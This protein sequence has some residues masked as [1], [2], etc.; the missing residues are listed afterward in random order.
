MSFHSFIDNNHITR[1]KQ[2]KEWPKSRDNPSYQKLCDNFRFSI[3]LHSCNMWRQ[4]R[5]QKL[6]SF[7]RQSS[8]TLFIPFPIDY[9]DRTF[10]YDNCMP[11]Y[12]QLQKLFNGL[13]IKI[14]YF[15]TGKWSMIFNFAQFFSFL[16]FRR[17]KIKSVNNLKLSHRRSLVMMTVIY[18]FIEWWIELWHFVMRYWRFFF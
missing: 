11:I 7:D 1:A 6:T 15:L 2:S 4:N 16:E 17:K 13:E 10:I 12:R 3:K 18:H 9:R 14:L 8:S 5:H